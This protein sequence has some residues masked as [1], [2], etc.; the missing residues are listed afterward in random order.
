M[1]SIGLTEIQPY[2]HADIVLY[3]GLTQK[4]EIDDKIEPTWLKNAQ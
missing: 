2:Y 1:F 3:S 4:I